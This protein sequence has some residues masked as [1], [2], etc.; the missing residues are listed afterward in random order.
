MCAPSEK[1]LNMGGPLAVGLGLVFASSIGKFL[2]MLKMC[3]N[4]NLYMYL[5][6]IFI[7]HVYYLMEQVCLT[8]TPCFIF[9]GTGLLDLYSMFT[10]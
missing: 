4:T 9:V 8:C 10:I 6:W 2:V 3:H 5:Q 7:V 1:F